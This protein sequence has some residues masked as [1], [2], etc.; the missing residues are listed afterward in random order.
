MMRK[1]SIKK[2]D[3]MISLK[4]DSSLKL[5]FITEVKKLSQPKKVESEYSYTDKS[6]YTNK[7]SLDIARIKDEII[8]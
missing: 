1:A 5:P 4:R 8:S 6:E 7:L 3:S 2:V